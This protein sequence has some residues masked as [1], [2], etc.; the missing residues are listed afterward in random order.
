MRLRGGETYSAKET[1]ELSGAYLAHEIGHLL[2]QFGHPFGQKSC[3]MN[4]T[5]MLRFREWYQQVDNAACP[6]G[7]RPEMSVGAVL[8]TFNTN[9][10]RMA[11]E[12]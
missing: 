9:W 3:V 12:P 2:F 10:L 6:I 8:P 4:P 1:A 5:S 11:S 7:C